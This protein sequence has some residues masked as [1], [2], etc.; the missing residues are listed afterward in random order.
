M[1]EFTYHGFRYV[2]VTGLAALEPEDIRAVAL[3]TD[4]QK[5]SSFTCGSAM[6]NAIQQNLLM[7]E[8]DNLHS[9]PTDCPQ[10][11]ERMAWMND[12]T[13]RFEETPYNFDVSRIFPKIML[14]IHNEQRAEGQFTCC[15]PHLRRSA[16]RSGLLL[17]PMAGKQA[18][19]HCGELNAVDELFD[20]MAAWRI[21]CF[22]TARTAPWI[23]PTTATGRRRGC[24]HRRRGGRDQRRD[25]RCA[26]VHRLLL[27][28][29]RDACGF[30]PPDGRHA[31]ESK[32]ARR[33]LVCATPS[34]P[35]GLTRQRRVLRPAPWAR[36]RLPCGW[37]FS[38][39]SPRRRRRA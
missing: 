9:I 5:R 4:I 19:M 38:R 35:S 22:R 17:L 15:S 25:A 30:C 36:R 7:T 32:Y 6:L 2:E 3:H 37:A 24:L 34:L 16:R 12:A 21:S 28:Q 10:R 29:L 1:P 8:K 13:V 39:R 26:D 11:D 23:I 14:D 20:G 33:R 18:L 27:L 31:A